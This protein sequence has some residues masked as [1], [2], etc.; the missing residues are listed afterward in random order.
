[1]LAKP[2]VLVIEDEELLR[3]LLYNTLKDD[4]E[5]LLAADGI[6]AMRVFESTRRV[7]AVITDVEMRRADGWRL[8]E[9]LLENM[10]RL[11]VIMMSGQ[12]WEGA[13]DHLL[14]RRNVSWL[15]Q[16]FESEDLLAL[17]K[18]LLET[19]EEYA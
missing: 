9:W 2:A 7:Q 16:P 11:P 6:E 14:E 10:P 18:R 5:V 17:L 13:I 12:V 3:K 8:V 1:M 4:Y 19:S 15:P